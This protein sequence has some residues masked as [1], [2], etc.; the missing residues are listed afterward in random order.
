MLDKNGA[1]FDDNGADL[2]QADCKLMCNR[3]GQRFDVMCNLDQALFDDIAANC[4][5]SAANLK[6]ADWKLM[7]NRVGQSF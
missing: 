7:C 6:Q 5:E 2:K 4:D 3:V 1:N